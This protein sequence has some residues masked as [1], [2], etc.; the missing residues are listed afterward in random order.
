M[1]GVQIFMKIT[2]Y[3]PSCEISD[4]FGAATSG[5][6]GFENENEKNTINFPHDLNGFLISGTYKDCLNAIPEGVWQAGIVLLGNAGNENEFIR[7]LYKKVNAPLTGGGAAINLNSGKSRLLFGNNE[8]AVFLISDERYSAAVVSENIHTDIL[9][10]H[11]ISFKNPRILDKIDG[12]DA[13]SWLEEKK[14]S[15]GLDM[16]DFEHLTFSDE[17]GINAHLS[18]VDGKICSGRDLTHEMTL[19]FLPKEK[20]NERMEAFYNDENAIVFGCA[21]LKSILTEK[22]S[23]DGI[24]LFMF[25]EVCTIGEKCDFGNLMLSKIVIKKI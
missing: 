15:L 5:F 11:K 24:G 3:T 7:K 16:N 19:R 4:N 20:V 23:S 13:V 12:V 14:K 9:S 2:F 18:Y 6:V 21:G 22:L 25:G 1:N 17:N 10:K 8:A